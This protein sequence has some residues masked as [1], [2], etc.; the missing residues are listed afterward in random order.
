MNP[1]NQKD[2]EQKKTE[3]S[4]IEG[5]PESTEGKVSY[6]GTSEDVNEA[7]KEDNE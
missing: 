3:E 1:N 4:P 2:A 5:D 7:E 6:G